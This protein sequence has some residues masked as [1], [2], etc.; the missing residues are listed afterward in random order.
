[1]FKLYFK[2]SKASRGIRL[3]CALPYHLNTFSQIPQA[4][5]QSGRLATA[6]KLF[7]TNGDY[8]VKTPGINTGLAQGP[9]LP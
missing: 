7:Q 1:M 3:F 5:L 9:L 6:I 4:V 8:R 2:P